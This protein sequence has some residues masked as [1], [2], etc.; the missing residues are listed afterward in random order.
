ME[1]LEIQI[2]KWERR[3][4]H[5]LQRGAAKGLSPIKEKIKKIRK[6]TKSKV[7]KIKGDRKIIKKA[8]TAEKIQRM[9]EA[10]NP[11]I[12]IR[13]KRLTDSAAGSQTQSQQET[14]CQSLSSPSL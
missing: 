8:I 12:K 9:E 5:F 1:R 14:D 10:G 6:N 13:F 3:I 7:G 4:S 11:P 2:R